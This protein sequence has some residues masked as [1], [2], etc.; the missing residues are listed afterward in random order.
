[1]RATSRWTRRIG[2]VPLSRSRERVGVRVIGEGEGSSRGAPSPASGE[3]AH[4]L[5]LAGEGGARAFQEADDAGRGCVLLDLRDDPRR[6]GARRHLG[7]EPGP[8][9]AVPDPRL[10]QCGGALPADGGGIPGDDP[11]RRLCRR[12]G[13]AVPVHRHA[14]RRRL[15]PHEAGLRPISSARDP[16]RLLRRGGARLRRVGTGRS[17][18]TG[19]SPRRRRARCR[20][21]PRSA[22][23]STPAIS[24]SSRRPA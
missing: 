14:A 1:M 22:R 10:R 2:K 11:R 24:I 4:P 17:R 8:F 18:R 13:G 23:C 7:Q 6:V 3:G 21:P 12:G 9:R 20:T 15:R 19:P 16:D 5:P